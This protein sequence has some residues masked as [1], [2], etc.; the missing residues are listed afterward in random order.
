MRFAQMT[1]PEVGEVDRAA[2]VVIPL[3]STEQHGPHLPVSTDTLLVDAVTEGL[4]KRE[5]ILLAPTVW[6]GHSPHHL[7]FGG[8][9]SGDHELVACSLVSVA[10]CF[11]DM[12]FRKLLFLNGH[13]GNNLPISMALQSLKT[14]FPA[15]CCWAGSYWQFAAAEIQGLRSSA[16]GGMGHAC[17]LETSL[18]LYLHPDTVRMDRIRDAGVL[19]ENPWLQ[20]EMFLAAKVSQVQNFHEFT[21]GGVFGAPSEATQ[22][23]GCLFFEAIVAGLAEFVQS[24]S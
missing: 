11:Y 23:K 2:L 19:H 9:L 20:S 14:S 12:G 24:V 5:E 3:G 7:S 1:A 6:L 4:E 17:E 8:T 13:G 16:P 18:M 21:Q 22:E 10:T 15:L